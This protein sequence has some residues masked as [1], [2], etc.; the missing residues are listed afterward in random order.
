MGLARRDWTDEQF[1][2]E[3]RKEVANNGDPDFAEFWPQFASRLAFVSGTFDDP[4]AHTRLKER[5]DQLDVSHGT[6]GNRLYYLAVAPEF[7]SP[8]I[9]HLGNAGLVYP[10]RQEAPWSRVVIEKPVSVTTW[11]AA[12]TLNRDITSVL[13]ESQVYRIDHYLG[14]ETVQNILALGFGNAISVRS[15]TRRHVESVQ[16]TVSKSSAW[17][18]GGG[19]T[20]TT[21]ARSRDMLQNHL[22]QLLCLVAMEAPRWTSRPTLVRNEQVKVLEAL[23]HWTPEDVAKNVVRGQYVAGSIEG[24]KSRATSKKKG[25][26]PTRGPRRT[27]PCEPP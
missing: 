25:S 18:E 15:G 11:P 13:D 1:R 16:I 10:S 6:R 4:A 5:L 21:Q 8:I 17:P 14:K 19:A 22:M 7:F 27:S 24:R 23:P 12:R 3:L 9:E 2:Q 20:T 26:N